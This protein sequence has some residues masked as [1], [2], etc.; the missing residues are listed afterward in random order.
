MLRLEYY[1]IFVFSFCFDMEYILCK[2]MYKLKYNK[3]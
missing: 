2:R 1:G 3:Y